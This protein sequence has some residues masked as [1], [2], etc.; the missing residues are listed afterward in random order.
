MHLDQLALTVLQG[1]Q[2]FIF[3][4]RPEVFTTSFNTLST[5]THKG[6]WQLQRNRN[7]RE[8]MVVK[9]A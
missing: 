1:V 9:T 5:R 3:S 6:N 2:P 8:P 7:F 4:D